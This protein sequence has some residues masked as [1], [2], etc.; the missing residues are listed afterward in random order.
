MLCACSDDWQDCSMLG[1]Y[2]VGAVLGVALDLDA[3][4]MRVAVLHPAKP[5]DDAAPAAAAAPAA[6]E[7]KVAFASG[8]R[9]GEAVG[10]GLFPAISG[11][12]GA[13]VE[14]NLG[15]DL[16]ARP[17]RLLPPSSDYT[18]VAAARGGQVRA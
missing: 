12:N 18:P 16:A 8:V 10:S 9:P 7:W 14:Y 2:R 13:K 11:S 15:D 17:L 3:G 1:W 4:A 5:A 6:V